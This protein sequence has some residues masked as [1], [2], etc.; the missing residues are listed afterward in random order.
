MYK[1]LKG[2]DGAKEELDKHLVAFENELKNVNQ[3]F[4]GGELFIFKLMIQIFPFYSQ[5]SVNASSFPSSSK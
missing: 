2:E 4:I 5:L 3:T 1:T